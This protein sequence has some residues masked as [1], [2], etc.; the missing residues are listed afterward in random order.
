MGENMCLYCKLYEDEAK[1]NDVVDSLLYLMI[2]R[3]KTPIKP[4]RRRIECKGVGDNN[5]FYELEITNE[6]TSQ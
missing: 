5:G 6:S 2:S 3:L 1:N 4:I